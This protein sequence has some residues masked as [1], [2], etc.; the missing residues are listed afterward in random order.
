MEIINE[1]PVVIIDA[2]HNPQGANAL[3]ESLQEL[4]PG[5]KKVLVTGILDDKDR[6]NII[7]PLGT[8]TRICIVT[9]PE[10]TRGR[11][12]SDL[13]HIWRRTFPAVPCLAIENIS[14]AVG[15]GLK[16][17]EDDDYLVITGSFYILDQA[18]KL[19]INT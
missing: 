1:N 16:L 14:A 8:D 15:Q 3:A 12:W 10:G 9:R 19:F 5:R 2:A 7:Y 17:L 13:Y 4:F 18:R 11:N 6:E